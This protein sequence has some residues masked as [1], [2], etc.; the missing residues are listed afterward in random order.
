MCEGDHDG[1][2]G[3][4][5]WL[6][7]G[8]RLVIVPG[9]WR[10]DAVVHPSDRHWQRVLLIFF[11]TVKDSQRLPLQQ[12]FTDIFLLW[13]CLGNGMPSFREQLRYEAALKLHLPA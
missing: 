6:V 12:T 11:V 4:R 8:I 9:K 5:M 2:G 1:V 3:A 10:V 7:L 13:A